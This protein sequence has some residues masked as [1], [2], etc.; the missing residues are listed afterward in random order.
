[1]V[2]PGKYMVLAT[3]TVRAGPDSDS[4]KVGEH[5]AGTVRRRS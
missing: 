3:A 5:K 1:M 4:E 2:E